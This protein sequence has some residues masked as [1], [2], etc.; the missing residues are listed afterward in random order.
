MLK[1]TKRKTLL[2][3]AL[4]TLLVLSG[5]GLQLTTNPAY[6]VRIPESPILERGPNE[7]DCSDMNKIWETR[8][9]EIPIE[10]WRLIVLWIMELNLELT[11]ACI[12]TGT[13]EEEC[14]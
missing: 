6:Q 4:T 11:A 9:V 14:K 12:A 13:P 10:D 8:C 1:R 7:V 3:L 2:I 5:C